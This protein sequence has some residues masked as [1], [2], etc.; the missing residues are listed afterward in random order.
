M[1][2]LLVKKYTLLVG[3]ISKIRISSR[4]RDCP[5]SMMIKHPVSGA[6]NGTCST[7]RPNPAPDGAE[8]PR[9]KV[10]KLLT[11]D[12]STSSDDDSS[13]GVPLQSGLLSSDFTVNEDFARRFE[14]NKRREELHKR[15]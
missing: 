14:H 9:K 11:A 4:G 3:L 12:S 15:M 8:P 10:K 13:G 2:K 7:K 1:F 6:S 5:V